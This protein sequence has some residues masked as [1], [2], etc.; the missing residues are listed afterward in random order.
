MGGIA[1]PCDFAALQAFLDGELNE[2]DAGA[3]R[4]HLAACPACRRELSRLKLLWLEL[5]QPQ[6]VD[7]PPELPFLRQQVVARAGTARKKA[8]RAAGPG[9]WEAQRLAWQPVLAAASYVPGSRQL[10]RLA[11]TTGRGLPKLVRGGLAVAGAL[12]RKGR[13]KK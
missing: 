6:D 10:G 13:G 12:S 11:R 4:R 7:L 5:E 9:L 2:K 3:V 8:E 1:L